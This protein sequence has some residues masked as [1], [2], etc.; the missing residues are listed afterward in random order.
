MHLYSCEG[1][2]DGSVSTVFTVILTG[3]NV[4]TKSIADFY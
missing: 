4:K 2:K 3:H 1:K